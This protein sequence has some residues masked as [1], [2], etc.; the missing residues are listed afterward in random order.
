SLKASMNTRTL[1]Q[2]SRAAL[3][4]AAVTVSFS[5]SCAEEAPSLPSAGGD[6]PELA[7]VPKG[8][9]LAT[10]AP[11]TWTRVP[12]APGQ[13]I[14]EVMTGVTNRSRE[15]LTLESIRV[16][17][18]SGFSHHGEILSVRVGPAFTGALYSLSPP[19]IRDGGPCSKERLTRVSGYVLKP[20]DR[21]M[22][23]TRYR[24]RAEG[25]FK[26]T[27]RMIRYTVGE[28]L[29]EQ[30]DTFGFRGDVRRGWRRELLAGEM[31]CA[32]TA[33]VLPAGR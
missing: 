21:I 8:H 32:P 30:L 5:V 26:T 11:D 12:M 15:P 10:S 29:Y 14:I 19:T 18:A 25:L 23:A 24:A 27:A 4:L 17:K 31:P 13:E 16:R 6:P 20:G 22:I 33:T 9:A 1:K 2:A 28:Q 7:R 3:L